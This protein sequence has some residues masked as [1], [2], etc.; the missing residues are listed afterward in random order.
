MEQNDLSPSEKDRPSESQPQLIKPSIVESIKEIERL[1][2]FFNNRFKFGLDLSDLVVLIHETNPNTLGFFRPSDTSKSW[3]KNLAFKHQDHTNEQSQK[4][5]E[6]ETATE[7]D[8]AINSITLSSHHLRA[9]P[10]ETLAH[11]FAHY[12]NKVI[13]NYK[14]NNNNYHTSQFKKRCEEMF[15]RVEKGTYGFNVTH[16]TDKFNDMINNE[17]KPSKTAFNIF[18]ETE[19]QRKSRLG[20][21]PKDE[22]GDPIYPK[23]ENGDPIIPPKPKPKG[24]LL[25]WVCDCGYIIRATRNGSK[26]EPLKAVCS[27]CSSTFKIQEHQP[28]ENTTKPSRAEPYKSP[29]PAQAQASLNITKICEGYK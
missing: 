28:S 17:F 27:H 18:Q 8:Q 2:T 13:D 6:T 26:A 21:Y 11:E 15:L 25:K 9:N 23:D 29:S 1:Y 24:R 16:E 7:Q 20:L 22:N 4:A 5:T 10:Y 14:G 12:L 19:Q 3:F